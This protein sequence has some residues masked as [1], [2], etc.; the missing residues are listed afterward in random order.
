MSQGC[1]RRPPRSI[2]ISPGLPLSCIPGVSGSTLAA[3]PNP[4]HLRLN[5]FVAMRP[6]T[7]RWCQTA[8]ENEGPGAWVDGD[9]ARSIGFRRRTS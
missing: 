6:W 5:R 8:Y 9:E 4:R 2:G 7:R 3:D 1:R